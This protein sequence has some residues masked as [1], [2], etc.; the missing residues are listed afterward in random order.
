MA[1]EVKIG[2]LPIK[3]YEELP[4]GEWTKPKLAKS[5]FYVAAKCT[6]PNKTQEELYIWKKKQEFSPKYLFKYQAYKIKEFQFCLNSKSFIV[7]REDANGKQK[8]EHLNISTGSMIAEL[9]LNENEYIDDVLCSTFSI[10][11]R[12]FALGTKKAVYIWDILSGKQ[13]LNEKEE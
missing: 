1:E 5:G 11:C 2:Q 8:M 9:Y 10:H 12:F 7:L 4:E 13:L 3:K 6:Y